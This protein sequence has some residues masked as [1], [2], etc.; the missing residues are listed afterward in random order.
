M[1]EGVGKDV[2]TDGVCAIDARGKKRE[3]GGAIACGA[4]GEQIDAGTGD[5]LLAAVDGA[6]E[7]VAGGRLCGRRERR[8]AA[9]CEEGCGQEKGEAQDGAHLCVP[10]MKAQ[11]HRSTLPLA[12]MVTK[13]IAVAS[14]GRRR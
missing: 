14:W 8:G 13:S 12:R 11:E 5:R 2:T 1:A 4:G 9:A 3:R 6:V 7:G 10:W